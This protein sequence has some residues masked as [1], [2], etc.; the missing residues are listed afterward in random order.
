M[1][2]LTWREISAMLGSCCSSMLFGHSYMFTKRIVGEV[3]VFTLLSWRFLLGAVAMTLLM[4]VGVLHI[5]FRTKSPWTLLKMTVFSPAAYFIL[6]TYGVS[7][8]SASESGTIIACIP[9]ITVIATAIFLRENPSWIQVAGIMASTAGIVIIVLLK[10]GTPTFNLLGYILLLG[11]VLS[12]G[13]YFVINKSLSQYSPIEKT[14]FMCLTGTVVFTVCATVENL[15]AGTFSAYLMMPFT[16]GEFLLSAAYLGLGCTTLAFLLANRSL[17]IL[18]TTRTSAFAGLTT[19]ISVVSGVLFLH[20]PFSLLQGFATF[21]VVAGIYCVNIL[22]VL[23]QRRR[24]GAGA[25]GKIGA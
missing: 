15:R 23:L 5:D 8:T 18:G 7:L 16:N 11:A 22:H 14:Y 10:E 2:K 6:E 25:V 3:S 19:V 20:E 17:T 21:L 9:I 24:D 1:G 12:Q 4:L 13:A